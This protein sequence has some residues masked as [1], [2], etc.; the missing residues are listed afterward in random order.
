MKA[1][2]LG[3]YPHKSIYCHEHNC[4]AGCVEHDFRADFI[5]ALNKPVRI[6]AQGLSSYRDEEEVGENEAVE[7]LNFV[8]ESGYNDYGCT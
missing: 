4:Q 8:L 2:C 7:G 6:N 3:P 5:S 1:D